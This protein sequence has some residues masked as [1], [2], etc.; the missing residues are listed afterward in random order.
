MTDIGRFQP[1]WASPPGDSILDALEERGWTQVEL[2]QRTGVTTKHVSDLVHGRASLSADMAGL[3][4]RVLGSTPQ[5]WLTR[6][7]HYRAALAM[8]AEA[9]SLEPQAAWLDAFPVRWMIKHG[10][11]G[12][13]PT[14]G[15]RVME[16]LRFF[17]VASTA[18]WADV[19]QEPFAAWRAS[20]RQ[21]KDPGAVAAWLCRAER[22][23]EA[24]PTEPYDRRR[25]TAMLPDLRALSL[26][27]DPGV[28]LPTL[29][30]RCAS[31]GV[32][33]VWVPAPPGCPV[34]GATRWL[35]P[36]KALLALSLRYKADDHLWFSFFHEVGHLLTHG[37]KLLF[38]EGMDGL[39]AE[40]EAEAD[41][42]ARDL[43]IPPARA[44]E[45]RSMRTE[46][47][48]QAFAE[49]EGIAPGVVVGRLQHDK[50][51]PFSALNH[52][53][54]RYSWEAEGGP[55]AE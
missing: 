21:K 19:W 50:C 53:K 35:S 2:A 40:A 12:D 38:L 51:I 1:D 4:S 30:E 25:F 5:F 39:D 17:R 15:G 42:F 46:S 7:A 44:H 55:D 47:A 52:L 6:E 43:L 27:E 54:A 31:A 49:R 37:K 34:S 29:R 32:A 24:V 9:A 28:F 3:L 45:L 10:W 23:A 18:V 13:A 22:L 20:K 11:I 14:A 48:V 33:L 41:A 36:D 16:M 8:R 26:V